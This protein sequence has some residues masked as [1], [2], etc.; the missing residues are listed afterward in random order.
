M[1]L[2]V[3]NGELSGDFPLRK[4][5]TLIELLIVIAIIAIIASLL[6]PALNSAQERAKQ[7]QCASHFKSFG[8]ANSLYAS[9]FNDWSVP[10]S[11]GGASA[12]LWTANPAFIEFL[13]MR[14][15]NPDWG[16]GVW[17]ASR[18]CPNAI[19]PEPGYGDPWRSSGRAYGKTYYG[20]EAGNGVNPVDYTERKN[21]IFRMTKVVNAS[22]KFFIMEAFGD[23]IANYWARSPQTWWKLGN[24]GS[25]QN[26]VAY[27][28][29]KDQTLNIVF[30]DGHVE[31]L[32]YTTIIP[33][34]RPLRTRWSPYEKQARNSGY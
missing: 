2:V 4:T 8:Q 12:S 17:H 33:D 23:A 20:G 32:R 5:F 9:A 28:H 6:L 19:V 18:V 24:N 22:Q 13:N 7:L 25:S 27:R 26:Y 3:N 10:N 21:K 29:G 34:I 16:R 14:V 30:F 11:I 31:N 1:R 15:L